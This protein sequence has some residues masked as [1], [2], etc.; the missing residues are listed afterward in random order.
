MSS[1]ESEAADVGVGNA[2]L[3]QEIRDLRFEIEAMEK[4]FSTMSVIN[5][6]K[7]ATLQEEV[8]KLKGENAALQTSL[9]DLETKSSQQLEALTATVEEN[10]EIIKN[11]NEEIS[12]L[13]DERE[14]WRYQV[15]ESQNSVNQDKKLMKKLKMEHCREVEIL[16]QN[17]NELNK[18]KSQNLLQKEQLENSKILDKSYKTQF[19]QMNMQYQQQQIFIRRFEEDLQSCV[20]L[21][22]K[23]KE[24]RQKFI[25]LKSRYL[26]DGKGVLCSETPEQEYEA[27]ISFLEKK[28]ESLTRTR[29]NDA[30]IRRRMQHKLPEILSKFDKKESHYTL[31]LSKEKK[32][33]NAFEKELNEHREMVVQ[34]QNANLML[35]A[36]RCGAQSAPGNLTSALPLGWAERLPDSPPLD[37][38]NTPETDLQSIK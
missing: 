14:S 24:L 15:E 8:E 27:K 12:S 35:S 30:K 4:S 9:R 7:C 5:E 25:D 38:R 28:L 33:S 16:K 37:D 18:V 21:I 23:S 2:R 34:L 17:I 36:V 20:P 6:A 31:L 19:K 11:Q 13:M 1:D 22:T 32:K 26:D 3:Y 29:Q 10:G